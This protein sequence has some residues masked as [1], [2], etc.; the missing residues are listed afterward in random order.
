MAD[1]GIFATTA[2]VQRKAGANASATS[3]AEAYTNDFMTQAEST[4]NCMCRYNFSD[5]YSSL[6]VDVKGILKEVASNLAAIYV[7]QYDMSGFTSRTEAEDMINIL[8]DAALRG[9]SVLRDKKV[10]DFINGA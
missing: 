7:I 1:T 4:I 6:N 5:N 9:L 10:Q 2:E 8:R 3:K